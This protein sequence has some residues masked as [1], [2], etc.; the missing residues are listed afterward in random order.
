MA[1]PHRQ[2]LDDLD[3]LIAARALANPGFPSMV[4]AQLQ[5]RQFQRALAE[6]RQALGLSQSE[7]ARRMGTSQ[8]AVARVEAGEIDPKA[9]T[10]QRYAIAIGYEIE[11]SLRHAS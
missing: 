9:S 8:S 10:L 4:E 6:H 7:V 3:D 5:R 1:N 2:A 11:L